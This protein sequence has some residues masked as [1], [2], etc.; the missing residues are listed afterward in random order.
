MQQILG[1][2][3]REGLDPPDHGEGR[4]SQDQPGRD[5]GARDHRAHRDERGLLGGEE[6][7]QGK[8]GGQ[9]PPSLAALAP[10]RGGHR[11]QGEGDEEALVDEVPREEHGA[12]RG[13]EEGPGREGHGLARAR[14][15]AP[16]HEDGEQSEDHRGAAHRRVGEAQDG[17]EGKGQVVEG[18]AVVVARVVLVDALA[19]QPG[20]EETVDA[21]VVVERAQ[22]QVLAAQEHGDGQDGEG[23]DVGSGEALHRTLTRR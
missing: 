9:E 22:A 8:S 7:S 1:V 19:D 18:G 11:E 10:G 20:Q 17:D 21:L 6:K 4:C 14:E 23:H 3:D 16:Q 15:E 2:L 12:R 5:E 13:G